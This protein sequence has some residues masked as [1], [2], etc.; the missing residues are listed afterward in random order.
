MKRIPR[1]DYLIQ[2]ID[3]METP[4]IKVI[5]GIRRAGKSELLRSFM[6]YVH[7]N[8]SDANIIHIDFR[9]TD[10]EELLD[11]KNLEQFIKS[12][13]KENAYNVVCIDEIQMCKGFEIAI[14]SLYTT[15]DYDLYVTGSNAFLLSSDLATLFTGTSIEICV[16][17]FSFCEFIKYYDDQDID[18][19]FDRFALEG[20]MSGA[21]V[22][23][24]EEQKYRYI[25][26]VYNTIITRDLH[27]RHRIRNVFV[28]KEISDFL[29]SNIGNITSIRNIA[30]KFNKA[31]TQTTNKT[32]GRYTE[33]LCNAFLFY[34]FPRYDVV[35]LKYI[36]SSDKYY[37]ADHAFRYAMLGTK[38][39][40][41]GRIYE[42]IVAMELKRRGYEVYVGK[43]YKKEID[44][45]AM[46]RNEKLYIQVSDNITDPKTLERET[47]PLLAIRDAYPKLLIARTRHE[48]TQYEGIQIVDLA[49]WL[50]EKKE[51]ENAF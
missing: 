41:Y 10:Y 18:E 12:S 20:G 17:P 29:M 11:R 48:K 30:E 37:L 33:L 49:R 22:Y 40:D 19:A 16:Y 43:L 27:D 50:L 46:K 14:N 42:N 28:L 3:V 24:R 51:D 26:N 1:T 45:V 2:L 39:M 15:M 35:G 5:T 47:S 21:Y 44:F 8:R 13:Y 38:Q 32:V 7:E 23:K 34:K 9:S 4:D 36:A 6:E 31:K 25:Q